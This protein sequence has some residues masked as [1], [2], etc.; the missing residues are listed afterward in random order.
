VPSAN[1]HAIAVEGTFDDCQDIVK[2]CFGDLAFRD[3]VGLGA[4][5]SINWARIMA[6]IVYYATSAV[7]LGAPDRPVSFAVP[8]GNFG[9]VYAGV[10]ARAMGLPVERF[11]IGSNRND[12]L[13]RLFT[14]GQMTIGTV[15]PSLSPSMDIQVS[16]NLERYLFD[17]LG[18]NGKDLAERMVAFRQS[19]RFDLPAAAFAEATQLFAAARIDDQATL[20]TMARIFAETGEV[21]DPHTAVGVAAG[22]RQRGDSRVPLITLAC[23]HPAKFV[24]ASTQ[25]LGTPAPL[26]R[27]LAGLMTAEERMTVLP[28]S[29]DAVR[30]L[31]RDRL[32]R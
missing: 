2:A 11:V 21:I 20:A 31:M 23:A 5:N 22:Q 26:P 28:N 7:A 4:V 18:R 6:Q 12:I 14:S 30:R 24:E 3:E 9:N 19:G 29:A 25:A 1:V 8:T 16:S 27:H 10:V 17:L 15:E 13:T 32:G